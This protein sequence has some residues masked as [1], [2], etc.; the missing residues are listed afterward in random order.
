MKEIE[1]ENLELDGLILPLVLI[2]FTHSKG[3]PAITE[4]PGGPPISPPEPP[5]IDVYD[6]LVTLPD[7]M[8][9]EQEVNIWP[10]LSNTARDKIQDMCEEWLNQSVRDGK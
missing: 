10:L 7:R 1:K 6:V 3:Y 2:L 5:E 4:Y 9:E 8:G